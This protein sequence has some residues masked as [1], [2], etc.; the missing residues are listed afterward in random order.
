VRLTK[1]AEV[2]LSVLMDG[3]LVSRG[4]GLQSSVIGRQAFIAQHAI[5]MDR[6]FHQEVPV[7]DDGH[8]V[9]SGRGFLGVALGHGARVGA[10]VVLGYGTELPNGATAVLDPSRILRCWPETDEKTLKQR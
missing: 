7:L 2:N 10:G 8:R 5:I 4:G 6:S 9:S 1:G 3:A